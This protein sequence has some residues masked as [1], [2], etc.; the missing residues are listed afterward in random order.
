MHLADCFLVATNINHGIGLAKSIPLQY[1]YYVCQIGCAVS[2]LSNAALFLD[3]DKNPFPIF[4]KRGLNVSLSTDDP[5]QFHLT[6]FP[7]IEEYS[8]ARARFNLSL[9][10][11]SE[12]SANSVRQSGFDHTVKKS[13]L[14]VT[15]N[16]SGRAGNDV[17]FSNVPDLRVAYRESCLKEELS[18]LHG[19]QEGRIPVKRE[20]SS[21]LVVSLRNRF[22]LE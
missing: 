12:I 14:G 16:R 9:V 13:W 11:M 7:L 19:A 6:S 20:T 22:F 8:V 5:L 10:D 15:Y 18:L 4:F 17:N 1:L 2:P 21:M 3:Y